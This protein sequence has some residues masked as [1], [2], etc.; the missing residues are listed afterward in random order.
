MRAHLI[1]YVS[2]QR[3]STEFFAFVLNCSPTLDVPGMSEFQISD[4]C[5]LGLMPETGI[6]NL[7]QGKIP[8]PSV[9]NGVPRAELYLVVDDATAYLSRALEKGAV[10]LSDVSLRDWGHSVGY[11]MEENGHIL[12]FAQAA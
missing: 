8:D 10:G 6:K 9:C 5:V 1:F 12:A 2:D 7:L 3:A 4:T 11:C